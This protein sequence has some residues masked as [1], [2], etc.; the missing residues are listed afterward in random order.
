VIEHVFNPDELM[1]F[2]VSLTYKWLVLSTPDR[3]R[4]Y[5][6]LSPFRLGPPNNPCHI[7]EWNFREFHRY[8]HRFVDIHEH[9]LANRIQAT[10]MIVATKR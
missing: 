5:T 2:L 9:L 6:R 7:R 10:Q 8:V 4:L 3:D 1:G